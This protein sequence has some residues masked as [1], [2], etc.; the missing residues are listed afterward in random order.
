MVSIDGLQLNV[1]TVMTLLHSFQFMLGL[2]LYATAAVIW[3][4]VISLAP[5]VISYPSLVGLTFFFV[6]LGGWWIFQE[7]LTSLSIL[8]I[9][10]I[11]A[12]IVTIMMSHD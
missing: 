12:G 4:Y 7:K 6:T 11:L 9:L 2:V 3:F 1:A 5:I 10:M 8:G